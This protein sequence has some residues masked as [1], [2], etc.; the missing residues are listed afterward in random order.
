MKATK[1]FI[2]C[3]ISFIPLYSQTPRET[4]FHTVDSLATQVKLIHADI[5]SP[6]HFETAQKAY[7]K[8]EEDFKASQNLEDIQKKIKV[9]DSYFRKAIFTTGEFQS[10]FK[11]CIKARNDALLVDAP[12]L[13]KQIWSEAESVLDQAVRLFEQNDLSGAKGKARKAERIY[14]Q[15]ELEAIKANY[16]DGTRR[17]LKEAEALEVK[18][19]AP[20]TLVKAIELADRAE[21]LLVED[22]YDTDEPR[23]LAQEAQY[24]ARHAL[25][26]NDTIAFLQQSKTSLERIL[27][28]AEVPIRRIA[29]ELNLNVGFDKGT[30]EPVR[31][32]MDEIRKLTQ[33]LETAKNALQEK[34][35]QIAVLKEQIS[36][37]ESQLGELKLK[38]AGLTQ[39]MDSLLEAQRLAREKYER[40]EKMFSPEE[41]QILRSGDKIILR[42]YSI[43]FPSGKATIE[44]KYFGL[45]A[46]VCEALKEYP[47]AQITVEG[48]TDSRGSDQANQKLSTERA[49]AV[50]EYLLATGGFDG[51]R[52][53]ALG[54]GE[55]R[56]I[57][58]NDTEDGRRKNRRIDIV[59]AP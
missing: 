2:L 21:S 32:I 22:R 16:L 27:L 53:T 23:Q 13:R 54:Y 24:E 8:A 52:I 6:G 50:R 43:T 40:V 31:A 48:H 18:K 39:A 41:A 7:Q 47:E 35:A 45:L 55:T 19:R 10:A 59:V 29:D 44:H 58:S 34:E 25:F 37:M 33:A 36:K 17:L 9:A 57:A 5:F 14:R 26:L 15:A 42:L 12:S 4:L 28:N 20:E 1:F 3:F 56:P 11:D 38:E 51:A 30:E 49:E 46:K